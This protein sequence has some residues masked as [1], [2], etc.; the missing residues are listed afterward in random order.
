VIHLAWKGFPNY[1]S[2]HH[3]EENYPASYR[4][5]K[6]MVERGVP[7]IVCAGTCFEYG[8]QNGRLTEDAFPF[9]SNAYSVAKDM[10]RRSLEI[11]KVHLRYD[12]TWVR[13]FY[14]YGPGQ[15][16]NA[17][18]PQ[19]DRAIDAGDAVFEMSAGEQ[20]RD[21]LPVERA[22]AY[23]VDLALHHGDDGI[24]NCCSGRPISIRRFVE[25]HVRQRGSK[26]RLGIGKVPYSPYEAMAF[27]GSNDKLLSIANKGQ[28]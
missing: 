11:L 16:P 20:L 5:I 25:E 6:S 26:I 24:V 19:L 13:L 1:D 14:L 9:P 27:W 4:F 15:N 22:A 3:I 8:T 23:L 10:L 12:L 28:T 17:L 7:K 2:L 21:Y 18:I